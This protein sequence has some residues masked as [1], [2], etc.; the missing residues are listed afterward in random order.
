MIHA[1][2][3]FFNL[4]S[5]EKLS[6]LLKQPVQKLVHTAKQIFKT[7]LSQKKRNQ[8]QFITDVGLIQSD[9]SKQ[10]VYIEFRLF[11]RALF[12]HYHLPNPTKQFIFSFQL[13]QDKRKQR[14]QQFIQFQ[15]QQNRIN[16]KM[17]IQKQKQQ[18]LI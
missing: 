18:Q 4:L 13:L 12:F 16:K 11:L 3:N 6:I 14:Q 10:K 1:I 17:K 15:K 8:R 5:K 9:I 7:D 2:Q